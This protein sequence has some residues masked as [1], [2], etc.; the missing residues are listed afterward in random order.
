MSDSKGAFE[1]AKF[2]DCQGSEVFTCKTP[3]EALI[4]YLGG[5][6]GLDEDRVALIAKLSPITMSAFVPRSIDGRWI[7]NR[8][9]DLLEEAADRFSEEFG[10]P[11]G[12]DDDLDENAYRAVMPAAIEVLTIFY[13]RGRVYSCEK[14]AERVYDAAEVECILRE[15]CP[16]WFAEQKRG[17]P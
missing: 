8:A 1:R 4:E 7:T 11:D 2:Y 17:T 13:G 10:N 3:Q 12:S 16:E 9:R 6:A 14:V 15:R 5:P